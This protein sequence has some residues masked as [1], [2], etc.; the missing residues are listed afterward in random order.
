[1]DL[2]DLRLTQNAYFLLLTRTRQLLLVTFWDTTAVNADSFRT[3]ERT[4]R[5]INEWMDRQTD[6]RVS[7]NSYLGTILGILNQGNND[8]FGI[9]IC[10]LFIHV[11]MLLFLAPFSRSIDCFN[12]GR[13]DNICV[14]WHEYKMYVVSAILLLSTTFIWRIWLA[15]CWI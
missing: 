3:H 2:M 13:N 15:K 4:N 10:D 6:R 9:N 11:W 8:K 5:Q 1:M 12:K 7:W 14:S